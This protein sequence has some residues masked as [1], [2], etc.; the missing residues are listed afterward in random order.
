M[1]HILNRHERRRQAKLD[2]TSAIPKGRRKIWLAIPCYGGQIHV[3]TLRSLMHDMMRLIVRGDAVYL[4]TEVGHADIYTARAQIVTHFLADREATDLV[5]ID[6]DLSWQANG[7][8]QLLDHEQEFVGGAYPK[9]E[10]PI[11][12]LVRSAGNTLMADTGSGLA[13]VWGLA[14]GFVKMSRGMLEQMT[15]HYG[16][17]LT[18]M[19]RAVPGGKTVRLFDPY[20]WTDEDGNKR[21]L[22]EDYAFCQRWRDIGGKVFLDVTIPMG[23]IG[24]Y[25]FAGKLGDFL[26]PSK[27][28]KAA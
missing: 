20:W 8:M 27:E 15:A 4:F 11:N 1:S 9:R 21:T 19:D 22:S 28:D 10:L 12:F 2:V 24:Q 6:S 26:Q 25:E 14:G 7:L 16:S 18:C 17:E 13:E 3:G 5:M 23:H